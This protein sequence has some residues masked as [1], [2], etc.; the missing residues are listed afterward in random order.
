[1]SLVSLP[2]GVIANP[3]AYTRIRGSIPATIFAEMEVPKALLERPEGE[4]RAHVENAMASAFLG[5]GQIALAVQS[6]VVFAASV[7]VQS[8]DATLLQLVLD[9]A[10]ASCPSDLAALKRRAMEFTSDRKS[11]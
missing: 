9:L 6:P 4:I 7:V 5:A 10:G 8:K 2:S 1:M 11:E 3:D